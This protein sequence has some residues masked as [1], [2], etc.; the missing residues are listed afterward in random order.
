[1]KGIPGLLKHP[2]ING[3]D[4][5]EVARSG[6]IRALEMM[7][8]WSAGGNCYADTTRRLLFHVIA[9]GN[10]MSLHW[11]LRRFRTPSLSSRV[12]HAALEATASSGSV[13]DVVWAFY[14]VNNLGEVKIINTDMLQWLLS[15]GITFRIAPSSFS[16]AAGRGDID[17]IRLCLEHHKID[18]CSD[19]LYH[20]LQSSEWEIYQ[21]LMETK[22][23]IGKC[24]YLFDSHFPDLVRYRNITAIKFACHW[25]LPSAPLEAVK[26]AVR[27]GFME[28]VEYFYSRFTEAFDAEITTLAAANGQLHVIEYLHKQQTIPFTTD[29]IDCAA[30]NGHLDIV[31]FL[32]ECRQEGCTTAA[33]DD[34]ATNGH[35][36]IV[37]YLL[38]HRSEG[39]TLNGL[40]MLLLN[41]MTDLWQVA[42][43]H[44]NVSVDLESHLSDVMLSAGRIGSLCAI[45]YVVE[46]LNLPHLG[47]KALEGA[48]E[49]GLPGWTE[50]VL[51]VTKQVPSFEAIQAAMG[52]AKQDG[53]W[54]PSRS[55][56]QNA[57]NVLLRE[58][59]ARTRQRIEEANAFTIDTTEDEAPVQ[60]TEH[61]KTEGII[62]AANTVCARFASTNTDWLI[63]KV[64]QDELTR[65]KDDKER[66][67]SGRSCSCS[68][69]S[70]WRNK[71]CQ[72]DKWGIGVQ[73]YAKEAIERDNLAALQQLHEIVSQ[74]S[75]IAALQKFRF[76]D[77]IVAAIASG[78][79]QI[80]EW[81]M[82]EMYPSHPTADSVLQI[83]VF[84]DQRD[85][86]EWLL[87][88]YPEECERPP[89]ENRFKLSPSGHCSTTMI[90]WLET[91]V[92]DHP[93][94]HTFYNIDELSEDLVAQ[95]NVDMLRFLLD[96]HPA[97]FTDS[98]VLL[99]VA[100]RWGRVDAL[101]FLLGTA[102]GRAIS[103]ATVHAAVMEGVHYR[104]HDAVCF[105]VENFPDL[106]YLAEA[107]E[108]ARRSSIQIFQIFVLMTSSPLTLDDFPGN[109]GG[110]REARGIL[111]GLALI[112]THKM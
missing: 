30:A 33:A 105:L 88:N 90:E 60:P 110:F 79:I 52:L 93:T 28:F 19:I 111:K 96:R 6:S 48:A 24:S 49:V 99:P 86:A 82:K 85:A 55:V 39:C 74:T 104:Q 76:D 15:K 89:T 16:E 83:A 54:L 71:R 73:T 109:S 56:R 18:D 106:S 26:L 23:P 17:F 97:A 101:R 75:A 62:L 14:P 1:M 108:A 81:V 12:W 10:A 102:D 21:L 8:D 25:P 34:A 11:L 78:S 29:A 98:S 103:D 31:R 59:S 64:M 107:Q 3:G 44:V 51:I 4:L 41:G 68:F 77:V 112:G 27:L 7:T 72:S 43:R 22:A 92:A 91:V 40:K 20:A 13:L 45:R 36:G 42:Q 47:V 9:Q 37:R 95:G 65:R 53:A 70:P 80:L 50:A 87:R 61:G 66:I 38:E 63:Q 84:H 100:A 67:E 32:Q 5:E 94:L 69:C 58:A 35:V 57:L 2:P 46:I